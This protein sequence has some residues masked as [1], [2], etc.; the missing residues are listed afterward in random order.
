MA[1]WGQSVLSLMIFVLD[2]S[3]Y[4]LRN[5]SAASIFQMEAS[6]RNA[7][8]DRDLYYYSRTPGRLCN[9]KQTDF[10]RNLETYLPSAEER[11]G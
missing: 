8:V 5:S 2:G 3:N 10:K 7:T 11:A 4:L 6:R 1:N 9:G